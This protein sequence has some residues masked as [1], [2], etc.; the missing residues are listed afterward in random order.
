MQIICFIVDIT[1]RDDPLAT[2]T[3][4]SYFSQCLYG[5]DDIKFRFVH[6]YEDAWFLCVCAFC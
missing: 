4:S 2:A 6:L 5:F 1:F 3:I